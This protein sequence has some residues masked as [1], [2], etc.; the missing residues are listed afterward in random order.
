MKRWLLLAVGTLGMAASVL[1]MVLSRSS[2]GPFLLLAA[3]SGAA[4]SAAW[5]RR[6]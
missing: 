2:T 1:W 6:R 3:A 5:L 4:L